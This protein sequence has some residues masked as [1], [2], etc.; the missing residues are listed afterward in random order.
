MTQ[1]QVAERC[2]LHGR[3]FTDWFG[4]RGLPEAEKL[5]V[6]AEKL[7]LSLDWLF[8]L[9]DED[10]PPGQSRTQ[11]Q[12]EDELAKRVSR[13]LAVRSRRASWRRE[14][15]SFPI[16]GS[17]IIADVVRR[18]FDE[19]DKEWAE[20]ERYAKHS[21]RAFERTLQLE[22][23]LAE[24]DE[25]FAKLSKSPP[26]E[27]PQLEAALAER[28]EFLDYFVRTAIEQAVSSIGS[29]FAKLAASG[30]PAMKALVQQV[31]RARKGRVPPR[32]IVRIPRQLP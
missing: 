9:T 24:Q 11:A 4:G 7:D 32:Y 22:I 29:P 13:D 1:E 16:D 5:K 31:E 12:L 6:I 25:I 19:M 20:I 18:E 3:R 8:G 10:V 2:G 15:G 27:A 17:A 28:N 30:H 23:V 14:A 21:V 26:K